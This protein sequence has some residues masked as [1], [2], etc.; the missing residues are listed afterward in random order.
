MKKIIF[1]MAALLPLITGCSNEED[2]RVN[3]YQTIWD[4]VRIAYVTEDNPSV[5]YTFVL[6]FV[7]ETDGK[8][9][10]EELHTL[11]YFTYTLT[12]SVLTIDG[13]LAVCGDWYIVEHSKNEIT[14]QAYQPYKVIMKLKRVF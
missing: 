5:S 3:L 9:A 6:E 4:G 10:S 7:T 1:A 12:E 2:E 8:C 11:Q 14:L 13:S